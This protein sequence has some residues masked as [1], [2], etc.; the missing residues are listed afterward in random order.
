MKKS[1]IQGLDEVVKHLVDECD[2]GEL[3]S[4]EFAELNG[5]IHRAIK[6]LES[7]HHAYMSVYSEVKAT[8]GYIAN[9]ESDLYIEVNPTNAEILSR[10]PLQKANTRLFR[11]EVTG[12]MCYDVPFSYDPFWEV[13]NAKS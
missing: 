5:Y 8:G 1:L 4:A 10:Y 11:N 6:E 12:I 9:H 7:N 3:S 13:R 2:R